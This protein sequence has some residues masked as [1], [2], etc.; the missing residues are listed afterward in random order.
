MLNEYHI[1]TKEVKQLLN[2]LKS[3]A[4][5]RGI[6]FDLK[7][8]DID[9]IGIPVTCPVLGIP[10]KFHRN[11]VQDDSVSFDRIDSSKGYTKDNLV[12][13]CHRV[14]KLKSNATLDEMKAI[15]NFYLDK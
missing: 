15:V 14:N 2:Q 13:V 11:K 7:S 5:R 4:K 8:T 10:L 12:I 3:S 9:E 6:E 1:T